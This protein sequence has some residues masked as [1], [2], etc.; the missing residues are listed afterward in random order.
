MA[1]IDCALSGGKL[2][3][4]CVG[5]FFRSQ[6]F[7]PPAVSHCSLSTGWWNG[8]GGVW[9]WHGWAGEVE[10]AGNT[11]AGGDGMAG[12]WFEEDHPNHSNSYVVFSFFPNFL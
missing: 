7:S 1:L 2:K 4:W 8:F 11:V 9:E 5:G 3:R 10:E 6:A 12:L